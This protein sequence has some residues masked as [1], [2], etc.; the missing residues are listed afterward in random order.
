MKWGLVLASLKDME[1]PPE[2]L[3]VAQCSALCVTGCVWTRWSFV[4]YPVNYNLALSNMFVAA[5]NTYQLSRI[6]RHRREEESASK[7][8]S[9]GL[10]DALPEVGKPTVEK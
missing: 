4:I 7:P 5:T 9:G 8:G 6:F 1:K 10:A 2:N 3:S